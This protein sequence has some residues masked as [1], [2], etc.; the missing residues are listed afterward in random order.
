MPDLSTPYSYCHYCGNPLDHEVC[1]TP[2]GYYCVYCSNTTWLNAIAVAVHIIPAVIDPSGRTHGVFTV[3]RG[4]PPF[5]GELALPSGF[6]THT[7]LVQETWQQ[8]ACRESNEEIQVVCRHDVPFERPEHLL[9]ESSYSEHRVGDRVLVVGVSG[10]AFHV[11]D[12]VPSKEALERV[13]LFP[14][15][16][17]QL[18]FSIHRKALKMYWDGLGIPNNVHI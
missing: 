11:G 9:T 5:T 12:F 6:I 2:D 16:V 1:L 3:R 17:E 10:G 15:S 18:C 14:D 4:I 7:S 8:A 13:I